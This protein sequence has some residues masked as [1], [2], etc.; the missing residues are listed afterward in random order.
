MLSRRG[1]RRGRRVEGLPRQQ[2]DRSS[3]RT[4]DQDAVGTR[5]LRQ[6]AR[7]CR[8][9]RVTR[10]PMMVATTTAPAM[11]ADA[12]PDWY[13]LS[14]EEVCSRLTVDPAIGL[15][16]DE[17]AERRRQYGPNKLAEEAKEP[18]WRAFLRQYR[19]LMQLVLVG[20]AVVS[21]LA[22]QDVSTGLV[23]LGLTV[24]NALMGLHQEGKAAESVAALRQ[25]LIMT[26]RVRRDG[27]LVEVPAEEL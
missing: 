2:R 9:G 6:R 27:E 24:L 17:V 20:A 22:L 14:A 19:D 8:S 5:F 11:P 16:A 4:A 15:S 21:V 26:A 23:V 7:N 1:V 18:G 13:R 25:M 3:R 10:R 12:P